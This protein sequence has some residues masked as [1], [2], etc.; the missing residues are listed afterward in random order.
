M[1]WCLSAL[2]LTLAYAA[3]RWGAVLELDRWTVALALAGIAAA[4]YWRK[5]RYQLAPPLPRALRWA[6]GAGLAYLVFQCTPLPLGVLNVL[7]PA[8][9]ELAH[10]TGEHWA[11]LSVAPSASLLLAATM[12]ACALLF[13]LAREA[14]WRLEERA[15]IAAAPLA[16]IA[17]LEAALGLAQFFS[18]WPDGV[19]RGTYINRNHYAGFLEIGLLMAVGLGMA[20]GAHKGRGLTVRRGAAIVA[21]ALILAGLIHSLSRMGFVAALTGLAVCAVAALAKRF[22]RKRAEGTQRRRGTRWL[23]ALGA[24]VAAV[25]V[26]FVYLPPDQLIARFA[27]LAATED[28]TADMRVEIWRQTLDLTKAYRWTGSGAGT[29]ESAFYRYKTVAPLNTV[30]Y[31][32]NDYLQWLAELGVVGFGVWLLA[33]AVVMRSAWR[34]PAA[35]GVLAAIALHSVVDFNLYIPANA[36]AVAWVAGIGTVE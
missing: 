26:L 2:S 20:G 23:M 8:R 13:V 5:R 15:W 36:M 28:I 34:H 21:G 12:A 1:S 27:E 30:D 4:Y 3:A 18:N 14:A 31:A 16:A 7:S 11:P 25:A 17:A 19:A 35:I 10:M 9:A 32:H 6:L 33:A 22:P 29:Y 24:V